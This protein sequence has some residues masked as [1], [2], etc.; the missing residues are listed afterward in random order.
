MVALAIGAVGCGREAG[1]EIVGPD[2]GTYVWVPA[3][4]FMMGSDKYDD[5]KPV[6]EVQVTKGFWLGKHEVTN[7]QYGAFCKATG[8][9][10]PSESGQGDD[11]P[12]VYVDWEDA[13]AYCEHYG[14][15][16]PTE[17]EWEYG[18][19][20]S[21]GR[22]YPWGDE[23]DAQKCCSG[24]N[25]GPGGRTFPVGSFAAS[26]SWCGAL[27]MAGNVWE[28]CSDWYDEDY[29]Q[30]SPSSDPSGPTAG[31]ARV[32]RGGGWFS[33]AYGCR[34]ALRR[35]DTPSERDLGLGF[36]VVV[37]APR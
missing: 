12:V 18:A 30:S 24:D 15:R 25:R 7:A 13:T 37:G 35:R 9:R 2:G 6:H 19:R 1:E 14:L 22:T 34:S 32:L 27:D 4:E 16:L 10:F 20:G 17:A 33:Y 8:R 3:G 29:Y 21:E 36:R 31:G 5:E 11:H 23:W 26:G 28:W